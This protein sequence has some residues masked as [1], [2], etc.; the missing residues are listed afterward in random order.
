MT[1]PTNAIS[2][3]SPIS[4]IQITLVALVFLL[5]FNTIG[6]VAVIR[7]ALSERQRAVEANAE[8]D[9]EI[10][11]PVSRRS[12]GSGTHMSEKKRLWRPSMQFVLHGARREGR[13]L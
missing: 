8:A 11:S 10:A 6:T 4:E 5:P 7:F 13:R 12:S 9:V 1:I 2:S 3:T